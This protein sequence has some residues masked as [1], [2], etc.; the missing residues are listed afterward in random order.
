MEEIPC[1]FR[2]SSIFSSSIES[3]GMLLHSFWNSEMTN[4]FYIPV[5]KPWAK[6]PQEGK[7]RGETWFQ[8]LQHSGTSVCHR[9]Q[10]LTQHS[11]HP[12][13]MLMHCQKHPKPEKMKLQP[14]KQQ[15][16]TLKLNCTWASGASGGNLCFS[17]S[18]S[19]ESLFACD[20]QSSV[21]CEWVSFDPNEGQS[22]TRNGNFIYTSSAATDLGDSLS[23]P[24]IYWEFETLTSGALSPFITA[25]RSTPRALQITEY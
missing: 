24:L 15:Q 4:R 18:F 1:R 6:T 7:G 13:Q 11:L 17:C 8:T 23:H 25:I 9:Q 2:Y 14:T 22:L 19:T 21:G 5:S 20:H 10:A 12:L 16:N 3:T